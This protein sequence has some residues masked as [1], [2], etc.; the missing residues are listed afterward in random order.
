M[1]TGHQG[2]PRS[3]PGLRMINTLHQH[4][5]PCLY[6]NLQTLQAVTDAGRSY[7]TS[8][9]HKWLRILEVC[10]F[11]ESLAGTVRQHWSNILKVETIF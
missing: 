8:L 2:N 5:A 7:I 10:G 1:L 3:E 11:Q 9:P 6:K 4:G